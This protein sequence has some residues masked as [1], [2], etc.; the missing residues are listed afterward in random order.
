MVVADYTDA[1]GGGACGDN[2]VLLRAML[3]AGL[4]KAAFGAIWDP[5]AAAAARAAGAGGAGGG[6]R[7]GVDPAFSGAPIEAVG[8]VR[9]LSD[10][11][12]THD[13]PYAP[14]ARGSFGPSALVRFGG[15]DVIVATENRN[16][17]DLQ[18]FRLFGIEP[19][20]CSTIGLKCMHGFRAAFEAA[21]GRV[22]SCDGGGL[23]TYNYAR[24]PFKALRRPIWPLDNVQ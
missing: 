15:I 3:E 12:Y 10:G 1:P 20:H 23:T 8:E 21:A 2:T 5:S 9:L 17:L 11:A 19:A 16:I 6:G 18:Q 4:E 22:L 14:G 13:G 7:G 24:L